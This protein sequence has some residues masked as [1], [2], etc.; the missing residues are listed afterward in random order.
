MPPCLVYDYFISI[1][2]SGFAFRKA[3][4]LCLFIEQFFIYT[5]LSIGIP[6]SSD[7]SLSGVKS[8]ILH[9][10][11]YR[12]RSCFIPAIGDISAICVFESRSHTVFVR[13]CKGYK[14]TIRLFFKS[15]KAIDFK[16]ASGVISVISLSLSINSFNRVKFSRGDRSEI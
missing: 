2:Q 12:S 16:S 6:L 1:R 7:R 11:K 15:R 4:R 10:S 5:S 14:S 13:P 8:W 9:P 3:S